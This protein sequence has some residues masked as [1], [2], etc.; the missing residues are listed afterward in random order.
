MALTPYEQYRRTSVGTTSRSGLV[1]MLYDGVL[2]FT[3]QAVHAVERGEF[4]DAHQN[5]LR[6]QDIMA[7]LQASLDL[8]VGGDLARNLLG[9]YEYGY[10][11]LVEANCRKAAPPAL[12]VI[13][14]FHELLQ[15]WQQ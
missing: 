14:L 7:E 6:A 13:S 1:I 15:S 5:F 8:E 2:R 11:R 10:R 12:E 9:L 3:R 4:E